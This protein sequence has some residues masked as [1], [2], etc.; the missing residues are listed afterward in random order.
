MDYRD[1][2]ANDSSVTGFFDACKTGNVD[3]VI[4]EEF[5]DEYLSQIFFDSLGYEQK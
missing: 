5:T 1:K 2:N 4:P 3:S